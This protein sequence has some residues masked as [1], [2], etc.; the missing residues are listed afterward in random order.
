MVKIVVSNTFKK[1]VKHLD[2]Q[3]KEKLEKIIKKII[4][5]PDI[6]KPLK[7]LRGERALRI[8]PFRI[9]YSFKKNEKILYLLKFEHR[10]IVYDKKTKK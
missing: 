10:K 2:L 9:I 5:N 4:L 8:N 6:G 1:A 7:Y 3:Q